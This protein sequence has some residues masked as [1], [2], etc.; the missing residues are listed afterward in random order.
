[1]SYLLCNKVLLSCSIGLCKSKIIE[2]LEKTNLSHVHVKRVCGKRHQFLLKFYKFKFLSTGFTINA[3]VTFDY[4]E[5]T[6]PLRFPNHR[7]RTASAGRPCNHCTDLR[8]SWHLRFWLTPHND[9]S[10]NIVN[11]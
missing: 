7:F 6:M 4:D 3:S 11:P 2:R 9:K 8:A 5:Y 10:E 1:M